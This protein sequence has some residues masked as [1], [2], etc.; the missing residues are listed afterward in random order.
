MSRYDAA[1]QERKRTEL[2]IY[3]EQRAAAVAN[4]YLSMATT[5]MVLDKLVRSGIE[6]EQSKEMAE[7]ML[8]TIQEAHRKDL[9]IELHWG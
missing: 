3:P 2:A 5:A 9:G 4:H 1:I 8:S 7:L 6:S